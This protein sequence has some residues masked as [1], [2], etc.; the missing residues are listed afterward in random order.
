LF[1]DKV[2]DIAIERL[3]QNRQ[4]ENWT[5]VFLSAESINRLSN[6]KREIEQLIGESRK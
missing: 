3:D 1:L 6:Q 2:L 4:A 5:M